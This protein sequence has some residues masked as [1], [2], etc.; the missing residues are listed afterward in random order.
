MTYVA[1]SGQKKRTRPITC[2]SK[3][4]QEL[5]RLRKRVCPK[6]STSSFVTICMIEY[7]A[8]SETTVKKEVVVKQL[9]DCYAIM[10]VVM[11]ILPMVLVTNINMLLE[12]NIASGIF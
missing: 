6:W 12:K 5:Y 3:H 7:L 9:Y 4:R 10:I 1:F 8:V 11:V 2:R